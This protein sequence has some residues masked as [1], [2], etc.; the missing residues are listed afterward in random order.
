M[1]LQKVTIR[2]NTHRFNLYIYN[3][4]S[5][6]Y[7]HYPYKEKDCSSLFLLI[8]NDDI[9]KQKSQSEMLN[10]RCGN[11]GKIASERT[12][13]CFARKNA[14]FQKFRNRL[15]INYLQHIIFQQ[16]FLHPAIMPVSAPDIGSI[17]C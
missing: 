5:C 14:N 16:I 11:R 10:Y 3:T 6:T 12:E 2:T 13:S 9:K 1:N 15:T 17:G 8:D 7:N 4:G